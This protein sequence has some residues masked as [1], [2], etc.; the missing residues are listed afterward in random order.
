MILVKVS[1]RSFRVEVDQIV[2]VDVVA[3]TAA[4]AGGKT[5]MCRE[6]T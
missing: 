1:Y 2:L 4:F 6:Q 5:A 3:E